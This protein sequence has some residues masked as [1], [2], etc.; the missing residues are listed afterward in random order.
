MSAEHLLGQLDGL[1]SELRLAAEAGELGAAGLVLAKRAA[2]A[3]ELERALQT[4]VLEGPQIALLEEIIEQGDR[5]ARAL[6]ARR[7]T[8]RAQIQEMEA[9]RR[10]LAG[11][12]PPRSIS[13]VNLSG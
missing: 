5:A 10:R 8:A 4:S 6:L 2:V 3:G 9:E 11:W 1:S 12:M 7:E 13:R